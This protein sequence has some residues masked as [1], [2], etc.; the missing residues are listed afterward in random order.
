MLHSLYVS[1]RP[2][3]IG[4]NKAMKITFKYLSV[5]GIYMQNILMNLIAYW[6]GYKFGMPVSISDR[7]LNV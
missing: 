3:D 1:S 7:S 5:V 6:P 2:L 4:R